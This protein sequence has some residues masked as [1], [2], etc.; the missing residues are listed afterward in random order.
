MEDFCTAPANG[1][2]VK[3]F[4]FRKTPQQGEGSQHPARSPRQSGDVMGTEYLV[5]G[6]RSLVNP[7]GE[8]DLG[9]CRT[10]L[11][12]ASRSGCFGIHICCNSLCGSGSLETSCHS[13]QIL[14][15][16]DQSVSREFRGKS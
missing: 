9:T 1:T 12:G 15:Q 16:A 13:G 2:T 11:R 5:P 3:T 14:L 4:P 10:K 7:S 8:R 6:G